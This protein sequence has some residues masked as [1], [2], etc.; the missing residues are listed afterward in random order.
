MD[1][2]QTNRENLKAPFDQLSD[3]FSSTGTFRKPGKDFVDCLLC[4]SD[5]YWE[6]IPISDQSYQEAKIETQ[7]HMWTFPPLFTP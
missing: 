6:K 7:I 5:S 1:L 2:K 3:M 4:V